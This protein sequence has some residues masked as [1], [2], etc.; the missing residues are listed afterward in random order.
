[1]DSANGDSST[2]PTPSTPTGEHK[3][4]LMALHSQ[5]S[6]LLSNNLTAGL[7]SSEHNRKQWRAAIKHAISMN[8][9]T[10]A[11]ENLLGGSYTKLVTK[12]GYVFERE[13]GQGAFGK[14]YRVKNQNSG[15]HFAVKS[16]EKDS[17]PMVLE[18]FEIEKRVLK[19][20]PPEFRLVTLHETLEDDQYNYLVLEYCSG[21]DLYSIIEQHEIPEDTVRILAA[22][23]VLAIQSIHRNGFCHR[24]IKPDNF[25]LD[26]TGQLKLCDFGFCAPLRED[27]KV[28]NNMSVGTPE[29]IAPEVLLASEKNALYTRECDWWSLG[30]V[31]FEMVFGYTPF[32]TP[33]LLRTYTII[34]DF[35]TYFRW[36][37]SPDISQ[38]A[39][40]FIKGLICDVDVRLSYEQ[41]RGHPFM[42]SIDWSSLE[43]GGETTRSLD[44]QSRTGGK[45]ITP[46]IAEVVSS[47]ARPKFPPVALPPH[48]RKPPPLPTSGPPPPESSS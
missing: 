46:P 5:Y 40:D 3:S 14:V 32:Q 17:L 1:V 22:E 28:D 24:D 35:K 11:F 12:F 45:P 31:I 44:L 33:N 34:K 27:G 42:K 18:Q 30:I 21:G 15:E 20:L 8:N 25:I 48:L 41:I 38:E 39:K 10:N 7:K 36:P 23:A 16:F 43:R 47:P 29:Y 2:P 13:I 26:E 19:A 4:T 37:D 6:S 9:V